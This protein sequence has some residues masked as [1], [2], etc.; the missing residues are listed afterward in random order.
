MDYEK[1]GKVLSIKGQNICH[2][3]KV[4]QGDCICKEEYIDRTY[5]NNTFG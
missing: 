4:Y 2:F 3:C 1:S 5:H